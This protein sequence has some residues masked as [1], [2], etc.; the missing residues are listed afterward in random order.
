MS[1]TATPISPAAH[2]RRTRTHR[3]AS[4]IPVGEPPHA[5][6]AQ[7][8]GG[9]VVFKIGFVS[10]MTDTDL[11]RLAR[12][13][14]LTTHMHPKMRPD[15]T[16]P[17]VARLDHWPGL[18]LERG[19]A[20]GRWKL[21]RGVTRHPRASTSGTCSPHGPLTSSTPLFPVGL[22]APVRAFKT[23]ATPATRRTAAR[24]RRT[25]RREGV[26]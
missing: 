21:A 17:G 20:I 19:P 24:D 23:P 9:T 4:R 11:H 18:F 10:Q 8:R 26:R 14:D 6:A 25:L 12:T 2:I 13:L 7:Q 1:A 15:P 22:H 5:S 16:S 3:P